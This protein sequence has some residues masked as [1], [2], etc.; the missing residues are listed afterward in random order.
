MSEMPDSTRRRLL[1]AL[2]VLPTAPLWGASAL[3][4][5]ARLPRVPVTLHGEAGPL[6]LKAEVARS[7]AERG[8]GLME[9]EHL[10]PDAGMLFLY[11]RTQPS[12]N[13][14]WMHRTRIPLDI[15]FID[16]TGRILE[17]H[18]MEPCTAAAARDCPVTRPA[19][20]YRAALE[21]NAGYFEEKGVKPGDC[22]SWPGD[23]G[24][25]REAS[26]AADG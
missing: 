20:A 16:E 5:E 22:V 18:R 23:G 17:I 4:Q 1:Q 15:A 10:P 7:L 25:C 8:R 19:T 6:R 3:A 11:E 24:E 14:F 26:M 21:V 9:R 2:L 12:R 13:G